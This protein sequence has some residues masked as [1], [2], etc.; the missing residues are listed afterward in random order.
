MFIISTSQPVLIRGYETSTKCFPPPPF[1]KVISLTFLYYSS[2]FLFELPR[3]TTFIQTS[4]II[5]LEDSK[6]TCSCHLRQCMLSLYYI[7]FKHNFAAFRQAGMT[8]LKQKI[9]TNQ[10]INFHYQC[11]CN[12]EIKA[13]LQRY[14]KTLCFTAEFLYCLSFWFKKSVPSSVKLTRN[15]KH[16]HQ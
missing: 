2:S 4:Y 11:K 7:S 8:A 5:A 1:K 10:V 9:P 15:G 3:F 6:N 14:S 16:G 13:I 12:W